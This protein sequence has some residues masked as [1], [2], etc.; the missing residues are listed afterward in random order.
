MNRF[1]TIDPTDGGHTYRGSVAAELVRSNG[2]SLTKVTAFGF[3][4]DLDLIS[5][6]TFFL[7]DPARGDH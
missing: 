6:F 2:S 5:N 7:D 4:Y 1:G 3:L